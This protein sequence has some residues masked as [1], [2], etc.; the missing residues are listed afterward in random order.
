M[1]KLTNQELNALG[2]WLDSK[3]RQVNRS[4]DFEL[5]KF[6]Y[7]QYCGAL[8][9]LERLG[10]DVVYINGRHLVSTTSLP[11]FLEVYDVTFSEILGALTMFRACKIKACFSAGGGK[12]L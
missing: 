1:S 10:A 3:E 8:K 4:G 7:R 9:I 2:H 5:K 12:V 11:D 6:Y